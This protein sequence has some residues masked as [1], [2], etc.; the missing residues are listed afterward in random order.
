M[1][2]ATL[3]VQVARVTPLYSII[4]DAITRS[5][6]ALNFAISRG[7]LESVQRDRIWQQI[8]VQELEGF[9]VNAVPPA[10]DLYSKA[11]ELSDRYTPNL[12]T[13]SLDLLHVAAALLV[14]ARGF[15][16]F[17]E[18]RRRAASAEGLQ[19]RP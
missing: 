4:H 18:R 16:S 7:R 15:F 6:A 17:D 10:S 13:R 5:N 12:A 19:V 14:N 3:A 8:E 1:P 9:F 2:P 11:Q